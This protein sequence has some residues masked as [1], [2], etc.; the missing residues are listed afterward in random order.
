[1]NKNLGE[2]IKKLR[3]EGLTYDQIKEQLHCSKSTI[4]YHLSE[5]GKE[6]LYKRRKRCIENNPLIKK[7]DSFKNGNKYI[8]EKISKRLTHFR[9]NRKTKKIENNVFFGVKDLLNTIGDNP[10]CYLTGRKINLKN[11]KE[12]QLDHIIPVSKGGLNT[13]DNLGLTCTEANKAKSDL[14]LVDFLI[15]CKEVLEHNG[16]EVIEKK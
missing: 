11:I 8:R 10:V 6:R 14:L 16:F 4:S 15:L 9:A 5:G 3:E 12:Y 1:M 2:Q 13:L 7:I